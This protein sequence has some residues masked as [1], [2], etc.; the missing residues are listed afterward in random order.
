MTWFGSGCQ[1]PLCISHPAKLP[2]QPTVTKLPAGVVAHPPGMVFNCLHD[3][4]MRKDGTHGNHHHQRAGL[5][6]GVESKLTVRLNDASLDCVS[7]DACKGHLE[8]T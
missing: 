5:I 3:S 2:G 1:P 8:D 6:K 7:S 4:W